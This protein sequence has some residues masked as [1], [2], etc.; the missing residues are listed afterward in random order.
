MKPPIITFTVTFL[1]IIFPIF[2]NC[3]YTTEETADK[4]LIYF[5]ATEAKAREALTFCKSKNLNESFCFLIDMSRHSGL[6]RFYVWD[7][8]KDTITYSFLV[9]HGCCN[10]PWSGD[11]SKES[12]RFSNV[13]GSHCSSLGKFRIGERG[14]SDW[15]THVKY[16]MHGLE[17]SNSNAFKRQIVFHSWDAVSDEETFPTGTPEGWGCPTISNNSFLKVDTMLKKAEKPA[18]MWI[19]N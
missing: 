9:G 7:F 18:L 12:P 2:S 13:D 19:Y 3:N 1:I 15:G 4:S 14:Y 10:N 5:N 6:K 17:S 16:F 11:Y 8:K